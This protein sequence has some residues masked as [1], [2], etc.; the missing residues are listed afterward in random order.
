[1]YGS[2]YTLQRVGQADTTVKGLPV[3]K[4]SSHGE[5]ITF[6]PDSD[7]KIGDVLVNLGG[8]RFYVTDTRTDVINN[9]PMRLNVFC[10]TEKE[11]ARPKQK[12]EAVY[13]IQN[14]YGSIIGNNNNATVHYN[15]TVSDLRERIAAEH[16]DDEDR[17]AME[18]VVDLLEMIVNNQ[19][20][21]SKGLLSRF[22]DVL[23]RHSWLSGSVAGALFSWL[24]TLL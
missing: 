21:P 20:P 11:H 17:E 9:I 12:T 16:S 18:K 7:V 5:T 4:A 24:T 10:E 6:L 3:N 15:S 8:D 2:D 22:S 23:E 1:M 19:I 14:A 13:N